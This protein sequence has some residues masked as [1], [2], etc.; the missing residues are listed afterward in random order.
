MAAKSPA[1][2]SALT[3]ILPIGIIAVVILV[4]L[5]FVM[6]GGT[7]APAPTV[8]APA[9]AGAAAPAPGAAPAPEAP[10]PEL[11]P[12]QLLK[13]ASTALRE[14]RIV[15]PPG[16]N[17]FEYYERLLE[18][19][20]TNQTAIDALRETFPIAIG[21]VEQDINAGNV[22]E[23]TRVINLLAKADPN[24]YTLTILRSKLDAKKKQTEREQAQQTAAAAAAAARAQSTANNNAAAAPTP[25]PAAAP[26]ERAASPAN[27]EAASTAANAPPAT[28][29]PAA[30]ASAATTAPAPA[31]AAAA[32]GE[33]HAAEVL[34][35]SPPDYPPDA[36]RKRQEGWVEVEFTV[37]P[38][39]SVANA[40]VVNAQPARVFNTSALRAVE[41]WTFKPRMENGKP[42]EEKMRRRIEFKF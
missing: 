40:A 8:K 28:T 2:S 41:R 36:V 1:S 19:E 6:S 4:V 30:P 17:A 18:K 5:Y 25:A 31:T 14:Q 38:D 23:A 9:P 32:G 10:L 27:N 34:K 37:T 15:A 3:K 39:G 22:D 21:P 29:R 42:V 16:N 24:N 7:K 35:T 20:P 33:S 26:P 12:Q 13:E 11:T